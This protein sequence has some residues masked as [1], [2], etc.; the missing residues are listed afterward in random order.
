MSWIFSSGGQSIGASGSV[1]PMNSQGWFHFR[2]IGLTPCCPRGPQ[3]SSPT[4]HFGGFNSLVLSLLY[5]TTLTSIYEYWKN[6]IF[7]KTD[8]C[9]QSMSLL[10]NMLSRLVIT[11]LLRRKRLLISWLQSP[12]ALILEPKK[13]KV[14]H[15]FHCFPIYLSW[16][17]GSERH[18]LSFFECCALSQLFHSNLWPSSRGF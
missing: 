1:L 12:F 10:F 2:F 15:C 16:S 18:D 11:F 6:H 17:D 13:I 4:P 7:D 8:L 5:G 14:Y 9:W 3:E